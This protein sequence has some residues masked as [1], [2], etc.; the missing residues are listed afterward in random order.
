MLRFYPDTNAV[1]RLAESRSPEDFDRI[2]RRRGLVLALGSHVVYELTRGFRDRNHRAA[3]SG[4]CRFLSAVD[5]IEFQPTVQ[6]IVRAE[7]YRAKTGL[8]LVTVLSPANQLLTKQEVGH[9]GYEADVTLC[10]AVD[11]TARRTFCGEPSPARWP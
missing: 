3:V 10:I 5:R 4:A 8:E 7:F 9:Y 11:R 6:A 2:A 1:Q